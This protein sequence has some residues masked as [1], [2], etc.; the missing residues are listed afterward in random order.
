MIPNRR[1]YYAIEVD[2]VVDAGHIGRFHTLPK[3]AASFK[4]ACSS[5]AATGSNHPVFQAIRQKDPHF[6]LHMGD[7]H[8]EN[9]VTNNQSLF[10][11]A[12]KKAWAAPNQFALY[13]DVPIVETWDDHD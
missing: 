13:R 11:A 12:Y 1:Y 5:C 9:I 3:G 7:L 6:F 8:Y 4:F 2:G 10:Q